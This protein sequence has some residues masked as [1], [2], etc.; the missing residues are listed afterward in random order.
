MKEFI[1]PGL[2]GFLLEKDDP[3]LL[4]EI[5]SE[6]LSNPERL[7]RMGDAAR[8]VAAEYTWPKVVDRMLAG[9]GQ[10]LGSAS[11]R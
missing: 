9:I 7:K 1:R 5:L 4:A 2:N 3:A 6:A 11:S 8:N 10:A